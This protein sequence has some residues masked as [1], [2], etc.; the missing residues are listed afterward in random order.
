MKKRS[1]SFGLGLLLFFG[2]ATAALA[3]AAGAPDT[4]PFQGTTTDTS[5]AVLKEIIG[6]WT[7]ADP[8]QG[9]P[10]L[11]EALKYFNLAV[12]VFGSSIFAYTAL[13]STL[14]SAHD[15]ELL[16][17]QW[18]TV[19][20]PIRFTAGVS[21]LVPTTSGL[22]LAQ[23]GMLWMLSQGVALASNLWNTALTAHLGNDKNYV[24]ARITNH[25][26]VVETLLG[27]Q[28]SELC[29]AAMNKK[30]ANENQPGT[31][32][33]QVRLNGEWFR[34][35]PAGTGNPAS[36]LDP[37]RTYFNEKIVWGELNGVAIKNECGELSLPN[38]TNESA[39]KKEAIL[40]R[41]RTLLQ[42]REEMVP[43]AQA[44]MNPE[45]TPDGTMPA[46][47][48]L[49][50]NLT[51]WTGQYKNVV[52]AQLQREAA[53]VESE[54][55]E[56]MVEQ[57]QRTG[58]F[59]AG[60]WYFQLAR[61]NNELNKRANSI[62]SIEGGR[63]LQD[64]DSLLLEKAPFIDWLDGEDAAIIRN[65][66]GNAREHYMKNRM[67]TQE[68]IDTRLTT[69]PRVDGV[70]GGIFEEGGVTQLSNTLFGVD[71]ENYADD[72]ALKFGYDPTNPA[73][74]IMQLQSVG[75]HMIN[76]AQVLLAAAWIADATGV[77]E[78]KSTG[79]VD[80]VV[81][82][83]PAIGIWSKLLDVL[84]RAMALLMWVAI[85]LLAFGII[86]SF[87]LPMLPFINW[88]GGIIGWVVSSL[89][90]LIATP[91]WI[92]AH[93]HPD[94][95]GVASR[96]A[97]SG[98]MI[99]L[100]LMLRPTLMVFG[101]IVAMVIV[102]P[103]LNV[104]SAMYLPAFQT[105][106]EGSLSFVI[107]YVM[108]LILYATLCW[109]AINFTF[110]AITSVPEGAMEW[111]GGHRGHNSGMA[112]ELGENVKGTVVMGVHKLSGGFG[113]LRAAKAMDKLKDS[114]GKT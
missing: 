72:E 29:V 81:D 6:D 65:V 59:T 79:V 71:S 2:A 85:A 50:Q 99:I 8:S 93:L 60:T 62:A 19:W 12:L 108:K 89:E 38:L 15:G 43:F 26:D 46:V 39:E 110:K 5:L 102:D 74:A 113:Q 51:R 9:Q 75:D 14:Q 16:G 66:I 114:T 17:K 73:P 83:T 109:I 82:K 40:L 97:A 47:T 33:A 87:W 55:Y 4:N 104:I 91:I 7:G 41:Y 67:Q 32:G 34:L 96:H 69:T 100:E 20:V 68:M 101:L 28:A 107:S 36:I 106:I 98:Y 44:T 112:E 31:Y 10:L 23:L 94:G 48:T 58:W 52:T 21:L 11:T 42:I 37:S 53:A 27:M 92:A 3:A 30:T 22:C 54:F 78:K 76:G 63:E 35:P 1:F 84:K 49:T 57:S 13:V 105:T 111:L 103:L 56:S 90:M 95:D 88:V 25:K 24:A 77:M 86:L 80:Q 61:I 64:K 70:L 18:S 45:S